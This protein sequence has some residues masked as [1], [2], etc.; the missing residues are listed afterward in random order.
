MT[1]DTTDGRLLVSVVI[2]AYFEEKTIGSIVESCLLFADEVLVVNDGSTDDTVKAA[3]S[4][5]ARVVDLPENRGVLGATQVGLKEA[6][7]DIIVTL[8]ADGQHDPAEI[9]R[10][11]KPIVEGKADLVM[12]VRPS[13]PYFSERLLTWMTRLKVPVGDASS[14]FRAVTR[15]IARKMEL[16]ERCM[17]GTFVL[18]GVRHGARVASVPISVRE[19]EDGN[20][21]IQ[22]EHV[23]QFFIVLRDLFW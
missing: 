18:E 14:G 17:C 2:P 15:E 8:D 22:T 5:G 21:R 9:P 11:I 7:S 23:A 1:D 20:R 16:H 19:R 6:S 10:V 12:G 3:R 4:A 13:F